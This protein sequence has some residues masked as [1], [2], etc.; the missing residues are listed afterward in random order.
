MRWP[1]IRKLSMLN[2]VIWGPILLIAW[3]VSS[4]IDYSGH[5]GGAAQWVVLVLTCCT[6]VT[7]AATG[8]WTLLIR[9]GRVGDIGDLFMPSSLVLNSFM[10]ANG[11]A[12]AG[13]G[14]LLSCLNTPG[15]VWLGIGPSLLVFVPAILLFLLGGLL[16]VIDHMAPLFEDEGSR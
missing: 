5:H 6:A 11:F 14:A 8:V 2:A 1:R 3:F 12:I 16:V 4:V 13:F 7:T 10:R 15:V 9:L